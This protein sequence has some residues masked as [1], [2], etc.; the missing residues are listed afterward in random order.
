M[1]DATLWQDSSGTVE[2]QLANLVHHGED[3]GPPP[4][5]SGNRYHPSWGC[6]RQAEWPASLPIDDYQAVARDE[7][8]VRWIFTS[9][10]E[11]S[12][13]LAEYQKNLES[14]LVAS[15]EEDPFEDG[16]F[17][18]SE[19]VALEAFDRFPILAEL[20]LL[21]FLQRLLAEQP[22]AAADLL[23]CVGRLPYSHLAEFG[24]T[25]VIQGLESDDIVVR[26]A[27]VTAVENWEGPELV[28]LL[29]SH[30]E[31]SDWLGSYISRVIAEL[32]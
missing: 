13:I 29:K 6:S 31:P 17:H 2:R 24:P 10:E 15:F 32:S 5:E 3:G 18:C 16:V 28:A 1:S 27:A 30:H 9:P 21:A 8:S 22:A 20:W 25:M 23:R 12:E 7:D 26:E 4:F 11:H 14:R 19:A